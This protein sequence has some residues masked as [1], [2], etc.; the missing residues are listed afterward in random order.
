MKKIILLTGVMLLFAKFVIGQ[1]IDVTSKPFFKPTKTNKFHDDAEIEKLIAENKIPA[2]GIGVIKEGKIEKLKIFGEHKKGVAGPDDTIF[3]VASLTKPI[4][5]LITLKLVSQ[6]KWNLDEPI[7]EYWIDPDVVGDPRSKKLTT[8]H[9]LSHQTGFLNWRWLDKSKKLKF[10]FEPGT[11]YQYSGEGFEYLRRALEKK[12][13][14]TFDELAEELVFDPLEMNNSSLIWNQ[15]IDETKFAVGYDNNGKPYE[16]FK[17]KKASAADN[18]LTT[19]ED[20]SKFLISVMNQEGLTQEVYEEM[21]THQVKTKN[22]KYFGLGFE[23]YNFGEGEFALSHGGSDKGVQTL[24][25]IIPKTK[26]GLI[27]FTNVDDGYKVYEKLIRTYL[28]EYGNKIVKIE[29]GK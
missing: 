3:N 16:I 18:L 29:T 8:R 20:Y 28:G 24:I 15:K 27:I 14:K 26:Q 21:I 1:H 23:I 25:F 13:G 17:H 4:T 6:A 5:A 7:Y 10:Q 12:F 22:D 19:V 11:K 2:L 9:I